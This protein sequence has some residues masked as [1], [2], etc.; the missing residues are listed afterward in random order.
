MEDSAL[1][2]DRIYVSDLFV[3]IIELFVHSLIT[4]QYK[5]VLLIKHVILAVHIVSSMLTS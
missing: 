3:N 4:H 1:R 2:L 5:L